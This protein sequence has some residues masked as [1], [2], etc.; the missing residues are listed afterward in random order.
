MP[1]V[2]Q[3]V[4]Q[5]QVDGETMQGKAQLPRRP[6]SEL[7]VVINSPWSREGERLGATRCNNEMVRRKC[8]EFS[9]VHMQKLVERFASMKWITGTNLISSSDIQINF[10]PLGRE[11]M[12]EIA[13][14][15]ES[16]AQAV[17]VK[18]SRYPLWSLLKAKW[19][20]RHIVNAMPGSVVTNEELIVLCIFAYGR[21]KQWQERDEQL[22][23]VK[24]L[25]RK[26][27]GG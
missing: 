15:S 25:Y 6:F 8:A 23:R 26:K 5:R 7:N 24:E 20:T 2:Q 14:L 10:T 3:A 13:H 1:A 9:R 12:T 27:F 21:T 17:I 18:G 4:L 22:E 11:K 19:K 16:F